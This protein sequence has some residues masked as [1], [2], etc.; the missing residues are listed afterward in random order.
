M[1]CAAGPSRVVRNAARWQ[2]VGEGATG[3]EAVNLVTQLLPDIA[4]LNIHMRFLNGVDAAR[5][6]S[7]ASP[8]TRVLLLADYHTEEMIGRTLQ[9][10]VRG[11]LLKSDTEADLV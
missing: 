7:K 5:L 2:V 10:G 11:Y 3:R 4:V 9:A 6:I 8:R 1:G